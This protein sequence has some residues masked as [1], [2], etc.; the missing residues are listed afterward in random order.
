MKKRDLASAV[1]TKLAERGLSGDTVELVVQATMDHLTAELACT[2]RLEYRDLGIF[3]VEIYKA[4]KM[5]R[6]K[7]LPPARRLRYSEWAVGCPT[8]SMRHSP[9]EFN[10]VTTA[11]RAIASKNFATSLTAC[12]YTSRGMPPRGDAPS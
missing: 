11:A 8:L 10:S 5:N 7:F 2:G 4:R 1:A 3:T 6:R 9:S 12:S